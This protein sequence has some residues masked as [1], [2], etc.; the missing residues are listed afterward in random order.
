MLT[1]YAAAQAE[2]GCLAVLV[3]SLHATE[4]VYQRFEL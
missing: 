4:N 3:V 1:Q 2:E